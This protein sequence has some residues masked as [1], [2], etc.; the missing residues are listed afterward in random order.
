M[1]GSFFK[2]IHKNIINKTKKEYISIKT[3]YLYID[4]KINK[5][6]VDMLYRF[7]INQ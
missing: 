3:K 2:T 7:I 6:R 5:W 1:D 4:L